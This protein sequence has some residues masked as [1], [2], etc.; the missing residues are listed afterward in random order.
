MNNKGIATVTI[1]III[2]CAIVV[3]GGAIGGVVAY[4]TYQEK[5]QQEEIKA[6]EDARNNAVNAYNDRINQIIASL[7][8]EKNGIASIDN[9]EDV[10]AMSN[11]VNAINVIKN[12]VN[13]DSIITQEQKNI[14]NGNIDSNINSISNR[15]NNVN[16]ARAKAEAERIEAER[17]ALEEAQRK[18]KGLSN[19][20]ICEKT[21]R[22]YIATQGSN[23]QYV[24]IDSENGNLVTV[25]LYGI[26]RDGTHTYTY[27]WYEI[28]RTTGVGKDK[29]FEDR[30]A[31][32]I[33]NY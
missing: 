10:D 9:N 33:S 13:N 11:A 7:N 14:I 32:N 20:E 16:E 30:P 27:A 5:K 12:E 4:N 17:K 18:S 1:I 26:G 31:F 21:R 15:I 29:T 23:P 3:L 19:E 8:V 24:E 6:M 25:H 28:D 22:Y 2:A